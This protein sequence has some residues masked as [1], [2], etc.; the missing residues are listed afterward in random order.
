VSDVRTTPPG[1]FAVNL[2]PGDLGFLIGLLVGEGSFGGDGKQPQLTLRMHVRHADLFQRLVELVPGSKLYGPYGH[3]GRNYFQWMVRG[4]VLRRELA[5][6]LARGR[7]LMDVYTR[8]RF[9]AMCTRYD[10][11]M[12]T[13]GDDAPDQHASGDRP[14]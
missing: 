2:S 5:P 10:I 7:A 12:A 6:E 1:R 4:Q 9:D 8:E 13:G 11:A 14:D 3:G